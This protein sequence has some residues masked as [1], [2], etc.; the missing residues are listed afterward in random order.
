MSDK[1][2]S[3]GKKV[4]GFSFAN[5]GL[6]LGFGGSVISAIYSLVLLDIFGNPAIVGLYVSAY[7]V[8]AMCVAL[9]A[10][11]VFRRVSKAR[12]MHACFL[13]SGIFFFMMS[14]PIAP[15]TFI[16]FDL[17]TGVTLI[18]LGLLMPLFMADFSHGVG[19]QK[20]N[21]RYWFWINLGS[22]VA[23]MLALSIAS[24]FGLRV[25]F[26]IAAMIYLCGLLLFRN[27]KIV[28]MDKKVTAFRPSRTLRVV[29]RNMRI[30]FRRHAFAKAY[31][32]MFCNYIQISLRNIYVPIMVI[33]ND[34]ALFG[35]SLE[36]TLGLLITCMI[37]PYLLLS[38][39]MGYLARKYGSRLW[40]TI[41]FLTYA[42]FAIWASFASGYWLL[43][44]FVLWHIPGAFIEPLRDLLFFDAS[45]KTE[46]QRFWGLFRTSTMVARIIAPLIAAMIIFAFGGIGA[47]WIFVAAVSLLAAMVLLKK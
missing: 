47:I 18:L 11:E 1:Y 31:F 2:I 15:A 21:A 42:G 33:Q 5:L 27:M 26:A 3:I 23:P 38:Q 12:L 20:L 16:V 34:V 8:F 9:F 24:E 30:F 4:S 40:L 39:P 32:V 13:L 45:T 28:Q 35:L 17:L 29:Y 6:I 7:F 22:L 10:S 14:F 41:G 37:V 36:K 44:I 46:R 19:M 43:L 25:P